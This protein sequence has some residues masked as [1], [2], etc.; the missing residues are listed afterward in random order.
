MARPVFS[1]AILAAL[2]EAQGSTCWLCERPVEGE[3]VSGDH[4]VPLVYG[5]E[6]SLANL[7]PAHTA[8]NIARGEWD[9]RSYYAWALA[10]GR[11]RLVPER[12]RDSLRDG[13]PD[14]A[15]Q[16]RAHY[17]RTTRGSS[18]EPLGGSWAFEPER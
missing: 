3:A 7:R 2:V 1:R 6:H 12:L 18:L 10:G 9:V 11:D 14:L 15:A 17:A 8:C 13:A 5:G 16:A 4:L